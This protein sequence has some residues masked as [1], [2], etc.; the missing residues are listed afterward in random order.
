MAVTLQEAMEDKNKL[1]RKHVKKT[2]LNTWT[3]IV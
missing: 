2:L 1:Q 3:G